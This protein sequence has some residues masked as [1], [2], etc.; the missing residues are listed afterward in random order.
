MKLASTNSHIY[1]IC[2]AKKQDNLDDKVI[3]TLTW[4]IETIYLCLLQ[5]V[6]VLD[7]KSFH[8][9]CIFFA[10]EQ[11]GHTEA[12]KKEEEEEEEEEEEDKKA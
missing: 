1:L 11:K 5:I 7:C 4:Y 2:R 12:R 8:S 9:L 3:V 10:K 6:I